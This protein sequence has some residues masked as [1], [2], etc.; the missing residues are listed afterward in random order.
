MSIQFEIIHLQPC[1]MWTILITFSTHFCR[2]CGLWCFWK[3]WICCIGWIRLINIQV[4]IR[5][6]ISTVIAIELLWW[7]LMCEVSSSLCDKYKMHI[8]MAGSVGNSCEVITHESLKLQLTSCCTIDDKNIYWNL[9][10]KIQHI[11]T[12]LCHRW[13]I[14]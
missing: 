1:Y 8:F 6:N 5:L 2:Q 11:L 3:S 14:M 7:H 12:E 10:F 9:I 4:L 13:R